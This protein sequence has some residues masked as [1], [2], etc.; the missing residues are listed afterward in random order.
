MRSTDFPPAKTAAATKTGQV[1]EPETAGEHANFGAGDSVRVK[2]DVFDELLRLV[3]KLA[4]TRNALLP[5]LRTSNDCHYASAVAELNRLTTS[6]QQCLVKTQTAITLGSSKGEAADPSNERTSLLVFDAGASHRMAIPLSL[7]ERL[8]KIPRQAIER[9]GSG[10]VVQ[11]R[12]SLLP[13]IPADA[14]DAARSSDPQQAI[15]ISDG[16]TSIGLLVERVEDIVEEYL[17]LRIRSWRPG[18]LGT[19]IVDGRATDII[20]TRHYLAARNVGQTELTAGV[21]S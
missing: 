6:L 4:S 10:L 9:T 3:A 2:V 19:A 20:D 21:N 7:I 17:V 15:V 12:G 18:I 11:C 1:C 16:T 13:L 14:S 8:E 5:L